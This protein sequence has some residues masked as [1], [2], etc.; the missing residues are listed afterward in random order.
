M[1]SAILERTSNPAGVTDRM[2]LLAAS[3]PPTRR[4]GS[5]GPAPDV[6]AENVGDG[7]AILA[8]GQEPQ[9]RGHR[10]RRRD[11]CGRAKTARQEHQS[12]KPHNDRF[13]H[14][15]PILAPIPWP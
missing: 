13:N 5:N 11:G 12:R 4:S 14:G 2:A 6:R 8:F 3:R 7:I 9:A 10:L 15:N 1:L